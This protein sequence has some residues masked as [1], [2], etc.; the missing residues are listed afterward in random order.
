MF[1]R[2]VGKFWE[3]LGNI[4]GHFWIFVLGRFGNML[5]TFLG[6]FGKIV[7]ENERPCFSN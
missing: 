5:G 2:V 4:L 7:G 1:L 6:H 3:R